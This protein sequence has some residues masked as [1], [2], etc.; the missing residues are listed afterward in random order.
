[1][2]FILGQFDDKYVVI[3]VIKWGYRRGGVKKLVMSFIDH[4][5]VVEIICTTTHT[6]HRL[7]VHT[8]ISHDFCDFYPGKSKTNE[9]LIEEKY[10]LRNT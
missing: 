3:G 5:G 9:K 6:T 10:H 8:V 4:P 7:F 1:M 2:C